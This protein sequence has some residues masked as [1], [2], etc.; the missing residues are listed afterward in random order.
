MTDPKLIG[1]GMHKTGTKSLAQALRI[2]GYRVAGPFGVDDPDIESHALAK[3]LPLLREVDA[4]QDNPWP[5]LYRQIDELFPGSKFVLTVRHP[6]D[7]IDSVVR[8]FGGKSTPM[9]TWIYGVGDPLGNEDRYLD[10]YNKHNHELDEYFAGRSD[11]YL[12]INFS[13]GQGWPEL[14]TFLDR[15]APQ[16][17][18]PHENPRV[19]RRVDHRV[20]RRFRMVVSRG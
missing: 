4:V 13:N 17:A 1:V 16:V 3:A 8:H 20:R 18:F 11:H 19:S 9:R 7:W 15:T 12:R 5:L 2:L 6:D 14:C 10:I